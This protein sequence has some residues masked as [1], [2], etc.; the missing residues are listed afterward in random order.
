M[1]AV[2]DRGRA[3]FFTTSPCSLC[4]DVWGHV[5]TVAPWFAVAVE[6]VD[7]AT[8]PSAEAAFAERVP[9]LF[10]GGKVLAEGRMSRRDVVKA[11]MRLRFARPG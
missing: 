5:R 3:R 9:V 2:S 7:I 11:L 10:G 8:D 1:R 6:K 4:D